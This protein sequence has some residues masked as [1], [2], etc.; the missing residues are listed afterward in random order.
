MATVTTTLT[1]TQ[2]YFPLTGPGDIDRSQSAIPRVEVRCQVSSGIVPATGAGDNQQ[3]NIPINLS[4]DYAYV[5]LEA[6][7]RI[8][9]GSGNCNWDNVLT[10]YWSDQAAGG[11]ITV[12]VPVEMVSQGQ[13]MYA[14]VAFKGWVLSRVPQLVM[15]P[16][17]PS[18]TPQF[19]VSPYNS[20]A[21]DSEY[22]VNFFARFTQY[23]ITQAQYFAVNTPSAVRSN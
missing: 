14:G 21:N 5:L 23:S 2:D 15:M 9:R 1:P 16:A 6:H 7:M 11:T 13:S 12:F 18:S 17:S 10:G 19:F 22:T 8:N 4:A 3:L 20:T